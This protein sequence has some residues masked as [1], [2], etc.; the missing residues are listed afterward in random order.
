MKSSAWV[1]RALVFIG[2]R[3]LIKHRWQ[4]LLMVLGVALGVAVVVAIDLANASASRSFELSTEM[5]TGKATHQIIGGADGVAEAVYVDLRKQNIAQ[6]ATPVIS[7]YVTSPQ[8]GSQ[9]M[10]LL[11]VDLFSDAPFRGFSGLQPPSNPQSFASLTDFLS[12]PGAV[13]IS[14]G[15]AERYSLRIGDTLD[16][17]IGGYP[18]AAH[19]SGFLEAA[20]DFDKRTVDGLIVADI[21]TAQELTGQIGLLSRID[22]ILPEDGSEGLAGLQ[23]WLPKGYQAIA[24]SSRLGAIA[25]MTSAFKLNLTALSMLA[26]LVG[27]FLIYNTIIFSIVQRRSLFGTLRCLGVTRREVFFLVLSEAFLVGLIGGILGDLLGLAMGKVTVGMVSQTVNDL[28]F[29]TIVRSV[30]IPMESLVK[31]GLL[32]LIA[33]ILAAA[34]PAWEAASIPPKAALLRSGLE[35]KSRKAVGWAALLGVLGGLTGSLLFLL[36]SDDLTL[37]FAGTIFIVVGFALLSSAALAL[38]MRAATPITGRIFG[39]VGR[40]APRNL[41]NSLSRSSVAVAAL[42]V[43]VAVTVGVGL[44]IDSFRG[45]V[46]VWLKQTLQSDVYISVPGFNATRSSIPIDPRVIDI[47]NSWPGV[48]RVDLLRSITIQSGDEAIQVSATENPDAGL[49]RQFASLAM[50]KER[51]WPSMESGSILISEP[52]ANR[53]KIKAAGQTLILDTPAGTRAFPIIGIYYDYTSSEGAVLMSLKT[54]RQTWQDDAVTALG[55][56]LAEEVDADRMT[57]ELQDGLATSQTLLIRANKT[58]SSDV[59]KVFDRT[60]AIT[61]SLRILATVVAFIGVL[62]ALLLLQMEK[63]RESG[64]LR[65]IGM[66]GRQ[67][68]KLVMVETGLMGLTAGLLAIPTGYA[69]ALILIY[70]INRRSF[71]W[72]LQMV[73]QPE[74]FAQAVLVAVSAALLAGVIPAVKLSRM[75]AAEAIR[76]E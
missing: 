47:V 30:G 5:V 8:L 23:A 40:M 69:L 44:M 1:P 71:G 19:I 31:G 50:T 38:F 42:M 41:V 2:W 51:V 10:Q 20:D 6:F 62:N 55:L 48:A 16:L 57:Q 53:L 63:Q 76:N 13:F 3:Y 35:S 54:Y 36:P 37:G 61:V 39:L 67:L 66:T 15:M 17:L 34:L 45:T 70:V 33:T 75:S 46:I 21:A 58:L 24:A 56:R 14:K 11:G 72:T 68:W 52:L 26:L 49:E 7:E 60:F 65:A 25:S 43:A 4:S 32:G 64:I 12:R 22:L 18:K 27:L 59:L 29:T 73:S 74:Q 28:Y 9:P